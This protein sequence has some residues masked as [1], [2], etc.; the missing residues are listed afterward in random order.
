M[1]FQT[2]V[3]LFSTL[4]TCILAVE[5][6]SPT[7]ASNSTDPTNCCFVIQE[8][9]SVE[10]WQVKNVTYV[11]KPVKLTSITTLVTPYPNGTSTNI[12]TNVYHTT[13]SFPVTHTMGNPIADYPNGGFNMPES[14]KILHGTAVTTGGLTIP[15]PQAYYVY[16]TVKIVTAKPVVATDGQVMC[17][18]VSSW[19]GP[20]FYNVQA[21]F[22]N[23]NSNAE[24]YFGGSSIGGATVIPTATS[25]H[26]HFGLLGSSS[27]KSTVTETAM[28]AFLTDVR[29]HAIEATI[30]PSGL[31]IT[32]TTPFI[33]QPT[34]GANPETENSDPCYQGDGSVN[35]G[36]V[37]QTLVDYLARDPYYVS[38]YPDLTSCLPAGPSILPIDRPCDNPY[39]IIIESAVGGD[40]TSSTVSTVTPPGFAPPIPS[41]PPSTPPAP[42]PSAPSIINDVL[43]PPPSPTTPTPPSLGTP[44][45]INGTPLIVIPPTTIPLQN[46]PSGLT[47]S[48]TTINGT[49]LLVIPSQTTIAA[50]PGS[51]T[52]ISGNAFD[53]FTGPTTVPVN[54]D[55]AIQ[56]STTVVG[57][58]TTFLNGKSTVVGGVTEVVITGPTTVAVS[59]PTGAS[60]LQTSGAGRGRGRVFGFLGVLVRGF[61]GRFR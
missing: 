42:A 22:K 28:G 20:N 11:T 55:L 51:I 48:T 49:P 9:V 31:E 33:Y 29:G 17:G 40:L 1:F 32:L 47:G 8:T 18:T 19:P 13:A 2:I 50:L 15:S 34:R 53:V 30:T 43:N 7:P 54:P 6:A 59:S 52:L 37:P 25:T 23:I 26:I 12:Y 39:E 21:T 45:T 35:Y 46:A 57:G 38:L 41:P 14:D 24:A 4:I 5:S 58:T 16:T 10:Y 60:F 56:G 61:G 36:Y 44:T 27:V 3:V